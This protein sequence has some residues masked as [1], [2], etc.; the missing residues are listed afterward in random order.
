MTTKYWP[1]GIPAHIQTHPEPIDLSVVEEEVRGWQLFVEV[2]CHSF[3]NVVRSSGENV[4]QYHSEQSLY[5]KIGFPVLG[6]QMP[7]VTCD[8]EDL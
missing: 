7:S 8:R 1:G 2:I 4:F 3:N 6:T 5:R